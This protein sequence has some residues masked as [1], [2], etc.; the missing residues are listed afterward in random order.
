MV[1]SQ[2][3][4]NNAKRRLKKAESETKRKKKQWQTAQEKQDIIQKKVSDLHIN[5]KTIT[6]KQWE[7]FKK[8]GISPFKKAGWKNG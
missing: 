2:K 1:T 7:K 3:T 4:L 6:L 8:S 5:K